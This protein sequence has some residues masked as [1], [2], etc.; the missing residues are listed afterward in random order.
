M[1]NPKSQ[2]FDPQ[3]FERQMAPQKVALFERQF[4]ENYRLLAY[5]AALPLVLTPEL[6][7]YLRTEF[8]LDLVPSWEAEAD[9]LLSDLCSPVGYELYA[10]DTAVRAYLLDQMQQDACI[11]ADRMQAV[12]RVLMS[13]VAYLSRLNSGQRERELQ[14]QRWAAMA[15]LGDEQCRQMAN[16]IAQQFEASGGQGSSTA[17]K[18][19][20]ARL[21]RITQEL[22][23]QL[24]AH[25]GLVEFARRVGRVFRSPELLSAAERRGVVVVGDHQLQLPEAWWPEPIFPE[26]QLLSFRTVQLLEDGE[27]GVFREMDPG[28][29]AFQTERFTVV[30]VSLDDEVEVAASEIETFEFETATLERKEG[31]PTPSWEIKRRRAQSQRFIE[32]LSEDISLEMV[33]IPGG[34]FMMGSPEDELDRIKAEGPQHEVTVPSFFMGRYPVTQAKW[35]AVAALPQVERDLDLDPSRFKGEN[36][37]VERVSWY[38]AVEFCQ[39]LEQLTKRPYRL[40]SEAEWEYACRAGT[41][42]PFYFGKTLTTELANY[43]GNY[44]YGDGPKGEYRQETT[45]VDHFGIANAFGLSDMHGNVWEWCADPFHSNYEGAPADGSAWLNK[46]KSD[47]NYVLRGGSWNY[48]P[49]DCRSAYRNYNPPAFAN[50]YIGF[51]VACAAP[52]AL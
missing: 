19:E 23:P 27:E 26:F 30:T 33:A 11:P 42:T 43:H 13:Y 39:R 38:D 20:F 18:A 46:G 7:H 41:Q 45:P 25:R 17:V 35:R 12:A 37:P 21:A 5:H 31:K 28:F 9:L 51:R 8:L 15:Y 6:V 22:E 52:R 24:Q 14:A 1:V 49:W 47:S 50:Y 10:M 36:R 32:L 40:P 44:T 34:S 16:E 3:E 4:G 29:P 48:S 2:G